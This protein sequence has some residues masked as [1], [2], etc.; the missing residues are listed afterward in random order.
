[1]QVLTLGRVKTLIKEDAD[2]KFVSAE[3][4]FAIAKATV[5]EMI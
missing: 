3:A 1:M 5:R 4:Y 2:V